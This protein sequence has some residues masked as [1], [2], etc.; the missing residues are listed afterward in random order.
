[1]STREAHIRFIREQGKFII[2]C[3]HAIFSVEEIEILEKYGH[4]FMALTSGDV[5]PI[6]DLQKEFV[7]VATHKKEPF[8]PE[9][10][11]WFKYQGRKAIEAKYRD[12]LTIQYQSADDEFYSR[13]MA[14]SVRKTM[15]K[16]MKENH[17]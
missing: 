8:S 12:K 10:V 14:K 13:E 9:E 7:L 15:F 3:N 6:T 17:K 2:D 16:V 1:M 11:A 5:N 4:W